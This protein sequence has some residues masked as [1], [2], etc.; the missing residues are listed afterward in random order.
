MVGPETGWTIWVGWARYGFAATQMGLAAGEVIWR[1]SLMMAQGTLDGG[2][3]ARMILEKP[4]SFAVAAQRAG[5][6]AAAG[7]APALVAAAALGPIRARTRSNARRLR[8]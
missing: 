8:R 1:R 2:E 6:A 4:A 7:R 5:V 3:L